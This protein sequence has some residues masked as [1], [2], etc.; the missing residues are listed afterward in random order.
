MLRPSSTSA[1][2]VSDA[3]DVFG[4]IRFFQSEFYE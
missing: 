4:G 1:P 2:P 3:Y